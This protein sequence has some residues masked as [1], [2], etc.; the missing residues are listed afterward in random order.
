MNSREL[1]F[2]VAQ[3]TGV[4]W[5][6]AQKCVGAIAP[7][8]MNELRRGARVRLGSLGT[9]KSKRREPRPYRDRKTK[10]LRMTERAHYTI[11]QPSTK[12]KTLF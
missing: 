2:A 7:I 5:R 8:V 3:Q 4:D 11:F 10:E 6:T 1:A 9:F 12:Y